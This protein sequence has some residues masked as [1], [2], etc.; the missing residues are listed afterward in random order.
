MATVAVGVKDRTQI[1][2]IHGLGDEPHQVVWRKP[3]TKRRRKKKLLVRLVGAKGAHATL[4]APSAH[5][6]F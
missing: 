3:L 1:Q 4:Y 2:F 6:V 5:P